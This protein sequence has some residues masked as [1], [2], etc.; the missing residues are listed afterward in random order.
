MSRVSRRLSISATMQDLV[1][2]QRL[3][4]IPNAFMYLLHIEPGLLRVL[5]FL[6]RGR[7]CV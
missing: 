5:C 1:K 4:P 2:F 3:N 7:Q 6:Q